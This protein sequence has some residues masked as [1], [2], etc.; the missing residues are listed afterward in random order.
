MTRNIA[1][2]LLVTISLIFVIFSLSRLST[3]V[4]LSH[5]EAD[6]PGYVKSVRLQEESNKPMAVFFHTDWC[7]SCKT[8]RENILSTPEVQAFMENFHPVK[9]NPE[10]SPY[11]ETLAQEFGVMGYPSFYVVDQGGDRVQQIHK[12]FGV[13]PEQFIAQLA[14]A[15]DL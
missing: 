11:E 13:S 8:L 15:A 1:I 2:T 5:W 7:T 14:L 9:I 3:D 12:T 6:F 4:G 10:N